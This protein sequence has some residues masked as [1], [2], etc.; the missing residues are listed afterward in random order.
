MKIN[1][2]EIIATIIDKLIGFIIAL[3]VILVIV[4]MF[5]LVILIF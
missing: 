2:S 3:P 1:M 4:L 5:G